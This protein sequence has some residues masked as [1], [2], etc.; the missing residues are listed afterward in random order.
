[1]PD[2]QHKKLREVILHLQQIHSTLAVAVAAL[3]QQNCELD[4]DI[5]AVVQ[6]GAADKIQDQIEA[7]E[8][9]IDQ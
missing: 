9:L 8:Q 7:I 2:T 5:A 6:R 4:A 3:K 1:M